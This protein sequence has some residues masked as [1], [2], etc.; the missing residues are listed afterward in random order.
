MMKKI[1]LFLI[2]SFVFSIANSC[3]GL[4]DNPEKVFNTIVAGTNKVPGDFKKHFNEIRNQLKA[5]SLIIVTKENKTKNVT[6]LEF[7]NYNYLTMFNKEVEGIKKL[8][9]NEETQPIINASLDVIGESQKIYSEDFTKIAK[10]IDNNLPDEMID[11]AIA[12]LNETKGVP[13]DEKYE[14]VYNL[15]VNYAKKHNVKYDILET[16]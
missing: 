5:G 9:K 2:A 3:K 14:K 4:D 15:L 1:V 16:L 6:A 8:P 11:E 12:K 7:V 13:L 10:M